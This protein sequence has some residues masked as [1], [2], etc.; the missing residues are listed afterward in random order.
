MIRFE[1]EQMIERSAEEVWAY[2]AD[3]LRHP[4]WMGV[5]NARM[6]SGRGT[7]VGARAIERMKVGPRSIDVGLEVSDVLPARRIAWR[8]L[9]GTP[10]AG[11]VR[12]DFEP[13]GPTSTR[14]VWSGS[15]GLTGLW[16]VIEPLIGRGTEGGRGK[17]ASAP[18]GDTRSAPI[19]RRDD[20]LTRWLD[21]RASPRFPAS[22]EDRRAR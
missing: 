13:L 12:L 14:A 8:V 5:K 19:D 15:M 21:I 9:A 20:R 22:H 7:E 16:R 1:T 10:L 18:E 3:V 11:E 2:A 6:V 4:E 17:R